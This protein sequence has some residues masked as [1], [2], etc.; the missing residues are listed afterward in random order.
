[1][2]K[3]DHLCRLLIGQAI[4]QLWTHTGIAV[5]FFD[6]L[7]EVICG[8]AIPV[9]PVEYLQYQNNDFKLWMSVICPGTVADARWFEGER[10]KSMVAARFLKMNFEIAN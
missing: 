2:R 4:L 6:L 1:M 5:S 7:S 3:A 9:T 10:C 8:L